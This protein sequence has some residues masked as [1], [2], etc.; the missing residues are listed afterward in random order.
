MLLTIVFGC[1]MLL[2]W[3]CLWALRGF[4]VEILGSFKYRIMSSANRDNLTSFPTWIPFFS[5]SCLI[6]LVRNS[7]T[8]LSKSGQTCLSNDFIRNGYNFSPF[9]IM[10]AICLS[11]IDFIMFEYVSSI[12]SFI[13]I[14]IMRE[15]WILLEAFLHLLRW[16]CHFCPRVCLL[17]YYIYCCSMF[18][19]L[20]MLYHSF[21]SGMKPI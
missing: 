9:S 6:A 18:I 4:L 15:Y 2:C 7:I 14:L 3:L 16:W 13:R 19:V 1:C 12:S 10:L 21:I 17:F 11:N 8:T 5:P 20:Q